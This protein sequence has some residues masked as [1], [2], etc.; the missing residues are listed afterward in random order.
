M[1][2]SE[3]EEL[4]K[5]YQNLVFTVCYQLVEDYQEAQNLTQETFL[6]A[7]RFVDN[8]EGKHIRPW[9][10][11]VA[12]N[13]AKDYLKSSYR[14]RTQLDGE[15]ARGWPIPRH[16]RSSSTYRGSRGSGWPPPSRG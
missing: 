5:Q 3:F 4:M 9:L 7:Y 14:R 10:C 2:E 11:R 8:C 15:G 16:R 12:A 6:A 13:K 1:R